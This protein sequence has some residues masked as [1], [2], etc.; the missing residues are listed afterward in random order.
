MQ[1]AH[2]FVLRYTRRIADHDGDRVY[3]QENRD[4]APA[5]DFDG[6]WKAALTQYFA[7][8]LALFFPVAHAAINWSRPVVSRKTNRQRREAFYAT[9]ANLTAWLEQQ[10]RA[11]SSRQEATR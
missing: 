2:L 5:S 8:F 7:P 9:L 10:E 4:G 3:W 11:S 6:A 1:V